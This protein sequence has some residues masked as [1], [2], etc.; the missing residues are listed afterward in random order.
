MSSWDKFTTVLHFTNKANTA[1]YMF[2]MQESVR[3]LGFVTVHPL[4]RTNCLCSRPFNVS[5]RW[6]DYPTLTSTDV[7]C[8]TVTTFLSFVAYT[9]FLNLFESN[10]GL[11]LVASF[12]I[13]IYIYAVLLICVW[14]E[15]L[16]NS[17]KQ[18][19]DLRLI[20]AEYDIT[21]SCRRT[22]LE[23]LFLRKCQVDLEIE[24][25]SHIPVVYVN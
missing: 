22:L 3:H 6:T 1:L 20:P 11:S 18:V 21:L 15:V 8:I 12:L 9:A 24:Q 4:K 7:S 23:A 14:D 10:I 17:E 5:F 13:T 19:I 25:R 16:Y 2:L